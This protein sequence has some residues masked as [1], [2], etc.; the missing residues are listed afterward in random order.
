MNARDLELRPPENLAVFYAPKRLQSQFRLI[1][2]FDNRL[3]DVVLKSREPMI[4]QLKLAWWNDVINRPR[5]SRATGERILSALADP[6]NQGCEVPMSTLIEAWEML[7]AEADWTDACLANFAALRS[8]AIFGQYAK[9]VQATDEVNDIGKK[10]ALADLS[11]RT[12]RQWTNPST[13]SDSMPSDA[14]LRPLTI[15][16]LSNSGISGPRL[17]WHAL[18]GR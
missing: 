15:L 3:A 10:W 2:A 12:G 4:A 1:L 5:E 13:T 18:T 8:A 16:A 6:V 7:A 14:V 11:E 9:W 17:I